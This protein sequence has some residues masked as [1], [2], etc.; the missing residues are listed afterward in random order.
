MGGATASSSAS[1]L[2]LAASFWRLVCKGGRGEGGEGREG[3]GKR[4]GKLGEF[5][6]VLLA[7]PLT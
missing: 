5:V 1:L 2:M 3:G 6:F 4:E 7:T